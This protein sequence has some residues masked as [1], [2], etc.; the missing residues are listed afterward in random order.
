MNGPPLV[1]YG[2]LRRWSPEKFRATLQAYFLPASLL[3]MLGY[4]LAGLWTPRVTRLYLLSL[5]LVLAAIFSG[6][7]LNRRMNLRQFHL[8]VH[9]GLLVI[10][11]IL[12]M[13]VLHVRGS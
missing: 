9:S 13:Q 3:G 1:I 10:A 8:Y 12:F 4:F 6:R 11:I 5:P 7:A 2:S